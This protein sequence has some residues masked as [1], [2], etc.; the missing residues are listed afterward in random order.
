MKGTIY[1]FMWWYNVIIDYYVS[2]LYYTKTYIMTVIN[3]QSTF[4]YKIKIYTRTRSDVL[5][6]CLVSDRSYQMSGTRSTQDYTGT[7]LQ[8]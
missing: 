3:Q 2:K 1:N 6:K 8:L 5:T 7:R 4:I